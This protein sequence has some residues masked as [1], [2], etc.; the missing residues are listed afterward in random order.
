MGKK[1]KEKFDLEDYTPNVEECRY[2]IFRT[3]EQAV[4]DYMNLEDAKSDEEKF[5]YESAKEFIFDDDY[6][7]QWGDVEIRSTDLM[8]I[9]D[10]DPEWLRD[11]VNQK[12]H[13]V[14]DSDGIISTRRRKE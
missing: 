2:V 1:D 13:P 8:D 12:L 9:V 11:K 3:I 6:F 5:N 10:M 7:M 14:L 4:K